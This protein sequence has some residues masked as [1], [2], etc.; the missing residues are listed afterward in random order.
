MAA[1]I[2]VLAAAVAGSAI[3]LVIKKNS[4]EFSLLL[5]I[6]ISMLAVY[7]SADIILEILDFLKETAAA[8]NVPNAALGVILKT[9]GVSI[10]TRL[11]AD[12]CRDAGQASVSSGVEFMGA[13][14][15]VYIALPLFRTVLDMISGLI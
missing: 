4:P 1:L 2:K 6:A 14:T 5:A 3:G 9:V 12:V 15:A 11:A 13:V 7:I 10:V 8:A